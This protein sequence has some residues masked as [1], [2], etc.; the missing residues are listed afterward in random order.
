MPKTIPEF[1]ERT[2]QILIERAIEYQSTELDLSRLQLLRLPET[3]RN[4]GQLREITLSNNLLTSLPDGIGE[5]TELEVLNLENNELTSLPKAMLQLSRLRRLYL[6]GNAKLGIPAEILG[7]EAAYVRYGE[8]ASRPAD[9]LA[10]YFEVLFGAQPL[11]EVKLLLVGRGGTGKSSIRDR[12]LIDTFDP[13][14]EETPGIQIDRWRLNC[15]KISYHVHV[16]DFAGQEITHATHRFF[17]TERSIY[18]LVLDARGDMQD[19]DAEYWLKLIS[20]FGKESPIIV[21]LNKSDQKPFDVD[22]FALVEKYPSIQAFV[23][24]DCAT[25]HGISELEDQIKGAL[26]TME[27]AREPFPESWT[28]LK[29]EFSKMENNYLTFEEYRRVCVQHGESNR[30]KQERLARILHALGIILHY[31]DDPRLRDTTVLNPHWVTKSI[32]ALLRLNAKPDSDGTLTLNEACRAL[33][34]EQR[35]MVAYLI[36]LMRRFELCFPVDDQE[37]RWLVPDLLPRFQ[38]KLGEQW[39]S[40]DALRLRYEYKVLPE[41]LIPRFITRTYPL[42]SNQLRW[43]NGVV[44]E[45][46]GA[47]ALVR[48]DVAVS[49][50]NV[51]IIGDQ[52]GRERLVKLIRNHFQ[53]IHADLRGLSP[54]ELIEVARRPGIYKSVETLQKDEQAKGITMVETSAGSVKVDQ[55]YELNRISAQRAR[56]P[57]QPRLKL[58]LSYSHEDTKLRDLFALNLS[59]LEEDGLVDPWFDGKI[60]PSA[61]WDHEIRRELE[62]ADIIVCLISTPFLSS[63]YI[64]GVE[65]RRA[66]ERRAAGE[67]EIVSILLEDCTWRNREFTQYQIVQPGGKPVCKWPRRRDAF[68]EV[69]SMLRK[70]IAEALVNRKGG[71]RRRSDP[72]AVKPSAA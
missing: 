39:L 49:Q 28:N 50:V 16:W 26:T 51:A 19:R 18:L 20:A 63:K 41:G 68:N 43:R 25:R 70:L 30:E 67:A 23:S 14:K 72:D 45:M 8:K 71:M 33:A 62:L 17:L 15:E 7:P 34:G 60:L 3:I 10:Y 12:L 36:D 5:L 55:T 66:L 44:L 4:A 64:R 24:T 61:D 46:E 22:R 37:T 38:P 65:M 21:A 9:I 69:E 31:S 27:S 58:F 1:Q 32:Y 42:S 11:N 59:L 13:N 48:T 54:R 47:L 6:N 52:A 35:G 29:N 53:Y 56:D 40:T 2:A 57:S